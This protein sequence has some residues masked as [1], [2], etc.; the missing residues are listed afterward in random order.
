MWTLRTMAALL[1]LA[2]AACSASLVT[3]GLDTIGG[4]LTLKVSGGLAGVDYAF[5]VT[6]DGEVVGDHCAVM[7]TFQP[8]DTLRVLTTAQRATLADLVDASGIAGLD[9]DIEYPAACCDYVSYE[10]TWSAANVSRTVEGPDATMPVEMADL[11]HAMTQ[12]TET[13]SPVR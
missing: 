2:V 12:L 10:L 5:H 9:A 11:V 1:A 3:P 8:G 7:C 13:S 4:T 6:P